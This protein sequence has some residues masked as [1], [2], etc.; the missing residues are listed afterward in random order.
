M[1]RK[2]FFDGVNSASILN[3]WTNAFIFLPQLIQDIKVYTRYFNQN[4][5]TSTI[6][7]RS[8]V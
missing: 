6:N 2:S 5:V 1:S 3:K 7:N 4:L 8:K